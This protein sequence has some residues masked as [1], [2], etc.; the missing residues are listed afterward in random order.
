MIDIFGAKIDLTFGKKPTFKTIFG[1]FL[2]IVMVIILLVLT[3]TSLQKV[4]HGKILLLNQ[5]YHY[6]YDQAKEFDLG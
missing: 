3:L 1:A 6:E 5:D 4:I 2:T